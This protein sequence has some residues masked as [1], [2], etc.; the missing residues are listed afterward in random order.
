[1]QDTTVTTPGNGSDSGRVDWDAPG[2]TTEGPLPA[3]TDDIGIELN[4]ALQRIRTLSDSR[5]ALNADIGAELST[6][7]A[8]G[9]SPKSVRRALAD[10][11]LDQRSR[12]RLDFYHS[13]CREFLGIPVNAQMDLFE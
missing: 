7:K 2:D 1:M 11:Q 5:L 12:D 3:Y 4:A 9:V 10:Q 13:K 8:L 6:L